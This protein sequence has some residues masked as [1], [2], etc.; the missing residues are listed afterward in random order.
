MI[1]ESKVEVLNIT[2]V[3]NSPDSEVEMKITD[4]N[5]WP[6]IRIKFE[7]GV[8]SFS[9]QMPLVGVRSLA[10]AL[11]R[12]ADQVEKADPWRDSRR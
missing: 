4:G 6:M 1:G 2:S 10:E 3:E 7:H 9:I 5:S 11:M 8:N 12:K